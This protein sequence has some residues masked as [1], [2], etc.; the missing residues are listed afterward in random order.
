MENALTN[1]SRAHLGLDPV[2]GNYECMGAS[3][4]ARVAPD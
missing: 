3:Y 1:V 2:D 4:L